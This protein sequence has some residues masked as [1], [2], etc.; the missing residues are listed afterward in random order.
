MI[1]KIEKEAALRGDIRCAHIRPGRNL[2]MEKRKLELTFALKGGHAL[3]EAGLPEAL[4]GPLP[5]HLV[6]GRM[7]PGAASTSRAAREAAGAG[8]GAGA[9]SGSSGYL[10]QLKAAY[11]DAS[12]GLDEARAYWDEVKSLQGGRLKAEQARE[13]AGE[14]EHRLGHMRQLLAEMRK[15]Q[16]ASG[17]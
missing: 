6:T 2:E 16:G 8:V 11:D 14:E 7:G 3:P 12:K 17:Q 10:A 4:P 9:A 15:V 5:M 1:D 13:A